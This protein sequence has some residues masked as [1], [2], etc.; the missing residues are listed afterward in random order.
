MKLSTL[1]LYSL[2]GTLLFT[3]SCKQ[4]PQ[5]DYAILSAFSENGINAVI[6]IPA[7]TNHKIEFDGTSFTTD[8]IVDFLPYPG[9]YGY[10]PGTK[11]DK[12]RGGDGDALDILVIAEQVPTGTVMEVKAIGALVLKDGGELDTKIIAIPQDS[13]L[14]VMHVKGFTSLMTEYNMAQTIIKDWFLN[15]KGLGMV[16]FVAWQNERFAEEEIKK[17][18]K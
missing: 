12:S 16:E 8:R 1:I 5:I 17:W 7:G 6:E 3:L 10:I 13:S 18:S 9:N 14:Q 4:N 15:Y 11:M 2:L